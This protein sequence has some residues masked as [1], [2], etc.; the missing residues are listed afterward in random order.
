MKRV[1]VLGSTGSIGVQALD[2]IDAAEDLVACGLSC[3]VRHDAMAAQAADRGIVHTSCAAGGGTVPYAPDLAPLIEASQPD[4]VL[5]AI[6]GAV[7]LQPTLAALERG[8]PVA[9]A[10]KE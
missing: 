4:L 6:V 7:G 2:V 1:L 9:L 3:A 8:L 10:N 5:N